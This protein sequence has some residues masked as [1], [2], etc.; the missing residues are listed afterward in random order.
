MIPQ[1]QVKK[2]RQEIAELRHADSV[3]RDIVARENEREDYEKRWFWELLQN[4][5]DSVSEMESIKVKVE[6]TDNE[7][8]FSHTGN[9]FELDDILSLIIQGSSKNN[10]EGKTGRFGTGFM[11]TY[12]LSKEVQ[13]TGALSDDQGYFNFLLNRNAKNN[14]E[15]YD[16]QQESNDAFDKSIVDDSYLGESQ[17]QTQFS[18]KLDDKGKN[19]AKIGLTCLEELIPITQLF[20]KQIES[21]TV[22][23]NNNSTTF[24][25]E[26][27]E[28]HN[29]EGISISEWEVK[30]IINET[31]QSSYKAYVFMADQY[32]SC[33]LT[34]SMDGVETLYELNKN[35]P[36]IYYT[37]PLIG[38]E[39]IGIPFIINSTNFD[40]RIE[41]D[42]VYLKKDL[43]NSRE[44][45]NKK[46]INDALLNCTPSFLRLF[47]T[48]KIKG[49]YELFNF[50]VAKDLKWIDQHWFSHLKR[51]TIEKISS[52]TVIPSNSDETVFTSL[53]DMTVPY[54]ETYDEAKELWSLLSSVKKLK[55]PIIE[56]LH[57]WNQVVENITPII[58]D[59][60]NPFSLR[61]VWGI[62]N[63]LLFLEQQ[64]TLQAL[65][66]SLNVEPHKWLNSVYPW[67]IESKGSF[68]L[69][70]PILLNQRGNFRSGDGML[71]DKSKDNELL[72]ISDLIGLK[73]SDNLISRQISDLHI[74]GI[75][76]FTTQDAIRRLKFLFNE[77]QEAA[78]KSDSFK[79]AN[80]KF[81]KWLITS[82][83]KETI[84]DLKVLRGTNDKGEENLIY[85][86]FAKSDHLLLTPKS[87]FKNE[88]PLYCSLV[89]DKD[90]LHDIYSEYLDRKDFQYLSE[91]SFIHFEPLI[92]KTENATI[93]LLQLLIINEDDLNILR[94]D[95]GQLKF[96]FKVTYT[97]F[98]Y[99]TAS[100]GHI[101]GRNT[102][103]RSSLE[104]LRFFLTEA[105]EKDS[106]FE[107]DQQQIEIE[108]LDKPLL[109]RECLWIYRAKK[110]NWI[111][112]K[113]ESENFISETPSSK[114]LSELLKGEEILIKK[115][116]GPKQQLFLNRIGIG[117]SDLV[118]NTL[119]TN[120]LRQSW[121][122]T[123]T[124]LITSDVSPELIQ[125]IFGD[126]NI[127]KEY[128]QRLKNRRIIKRNQ[129]IGGL[130]EKLFVEYI[131][132][133]RKNGYSLNIQREPFGSDYV[134]SEESSDLVNDNNQREGFKVD[135][136]LIELKATGKE[137]A[138]MT[139][140]QA[141]TAAEQKD[142]YALI[143]VPLDGSDP[144]LEYLRLNSK[145]ITNIG[146]KVKDV[147]VD[148]DD[149]ESRKH[150][151]YSGKNGVSVNIED[152]NIRFNINSSVWKT[153]LTTIESFIKSLFS[154]FSQAIGNTTSL[155]K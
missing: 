143:V 104:R 7:V 100:D 14:E 110:L 93:S 111:N 72:A 3:Y 37:F 40:P 117:I 80:A 22:I 83:Q 120:E 5:K 11:T 53:N 82:K 146:Y 8:V 135:N 63:L 136:W 26:Q 74:S 61:F 54:S 60:E 86:H 90:C 38:T 56:D 101:Y 141:K 125:E 45:L 96:Q 55:V 119:A 73:I 123:I 36:R 112:V 152:Q 66:E 17:F 25:K 150:K 84:Q 154:K 46:I 145:V 33:V 78:S 70:K 153:E 114:N 23:E 95:E 138:A 1:E 107:N 87:F 57:K 115:V 151:L 130:V 133:F 144:D 149:I 134:L 44:S 69:E 99:L 127:Q 140:L 2:R 39:E 113:S 118:R 16:R 124:N 10:Q 81:L 77:A 42:G 148:F 116:R 49:N 121:D 41:R 122:K 108:G 34:K 32:E 88:Y 89:R 94:D 12:L 48:K 50:C 18:Y 155:E 128:A 65:E 21:V 132:E 15:F 13:I 126:P 97:D 79:S 147:I 139:P 29:S 76:N 103:Q 106:S 98:A 105:V 131:Q 75:E 91:N 92:R 27:I 9:P 62:K 51:S 20:N 52:E 64:K 137:Y 31:K 43:E 35:F 142:N 30:T 68:P 109:L 85:D 71:W 129:N 102:T 47:K 28:I 4:A 6:V 19:T 59:N 67:V 24:S 58:V